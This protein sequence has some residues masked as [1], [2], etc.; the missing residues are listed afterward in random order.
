MKFRVRDYGNDEYDIEEVEETPVSPQPK[1]D[2]EISEELVL[3]QDEIKVLKEIVAERLAQSS[4]DD[5]ME[6]EEE[7]EEEEE[8]I[9]TDSMKDSIGKR[10]KIKTKDSEENDFEEVINNNWRNRYGGNN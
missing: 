3:T 2:D 4:K 6:E 9:D 5:D 7:E 10:V 1:D 8:I